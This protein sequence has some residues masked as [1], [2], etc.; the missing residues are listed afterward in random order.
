MNLAQRL[1]EGTQFAIFSFV[2]HEPCKLRSASAIL[3]PS[4]GKISS[5]RIQASCCLHSVSWALD[6]GALL[7]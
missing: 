4:L 5:H 2:T 7:L 6:R 3:D 1:F